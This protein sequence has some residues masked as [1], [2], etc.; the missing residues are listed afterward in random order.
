MKTCKNPECG[1]EIPENL[2]YCN[3]QCLRKHLEI[4]KEAKTKPQIEEYP[5]RNGKNTEPTV[6][7]LES[8]REPQWK[9]TLSQ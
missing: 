6:G 3:E 2:N 9:A 1:K 8:R 7:I 4:K 5:R